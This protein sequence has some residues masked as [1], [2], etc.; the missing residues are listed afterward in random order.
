MYFVIAIVFAFVTTLTSGCAKGSP[1]VPPVPE[2]HEEM[3]ALSASIRT[4]ASVCK[5]EASKNECNQGDNTLW[6]GL[7]CASGEAFACEAVRKMQ[8][9]EGW[10]RRSGSRVGNVTELNP[11]SRDMVLGFALYVQ[12]TGDRPAV[13]RLLAYWKQ[14]G[15]LGPRCDDRCIATPLVLNALRVAAGIGT[16]QVADHIF[17]LQNAQGAPAGYARHLAMIEVWIRKRAGWK[18]QII[19]EAA[20]VLAKR[21]PSNGFFAYVAGDRE[22][23]T[24]IFIDLAPRSKPE[25]TSQWSFE[26]TDSSEAWRESMG[27]EWTALSNLLSK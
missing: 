10:V 25:E 15:R 23:A 6:N 16:G 20:K 3:L 26:R 24:E 4:W 11:T 14:T 13:E 17:V 22:R 21:E 7:L 27:W 9:P 2:P 5:G 8:E 19:D 12:T 1:E 18:G